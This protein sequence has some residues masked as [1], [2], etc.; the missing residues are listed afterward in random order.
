MPA[1]KRETR[2]L[3]RAVKEQI[4][5]AASK[6]NLTEHEVLNGSQ[7]PSVVSARIEV[8]RFLRDRGYSY[9]Q[10]AAV[11]GMHHT[12]V[13]RHLKGRPEPKREPAPFP[14]YSGEWAI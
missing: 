6:Y 12:T 8:M 9:P 13:L 11:F 5:S 3:A 14:D 10:I 4:S 7:H 1:R 2:H